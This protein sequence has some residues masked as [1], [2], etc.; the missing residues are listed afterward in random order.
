VAKYLIFGDVH[1]GPTPSSCTGTYVDDLFD[2][3]EQC[4]YL[5]RSRNVAAVVIAGDLF[6]SK[7]PTRTS[8]A[9]VTRLIKLLRRFG[10]TVW[11]VPGNH[12]MQHDRIESLDETQPAGELLASGVVKLLDGW[13]DEYKH[14]YG[15]PWQQL[16]EDE[17]VFGALA[18]YRSLHETR[19][20]EH[21]LV[22]THAPLYPPGLELAYEFYPPGRWAYAMG[23]GQHSCY[24]GHVHERAG[25]WQV[26]PPDLRPGHDVVYAGDPPGASVVTF[27]NPGAL[28]R[29]SLHEH[30]LTRMPAVAIWDSAD[31]QFT[32]ITLNAKPPEEVFRLQENRQTTDMTGRL[33]E[34]L[35]SVGSTQLEVMSV[36]SVAAHVRGLG[37][38]EADTTL[39]IELLMEAANVR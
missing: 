7:A 27:C 25:I 39:A 15:V 35:V 32:E 17:I 29:G 36:E 19:P 30:N 34:F 14:L 38:S 18:D 5:A 13:D 22:V 9:L 28:S 37:L 4:I 11:F 24:Y 23:P 12:D 10:V 31:G 20:P 8:H 6:H 26:Q 21:S 2:L 16:W 33:E 1:L 3:L